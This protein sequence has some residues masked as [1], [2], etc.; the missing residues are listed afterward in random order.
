MRR[1]L[2]YLLALL[3]AAPLASTIPAHAQDW[4]KARLEASARH[5]EWV[6]LKH[7]GRTVN[8]YVVYPESSKKTPVV[9]LI[10]EIFGAS[11][12][13]HEMADEIAA[14]GYIVIAPD[15]LSGYGPN[16][17]GSDAFSGQEAAMKAVSGLDPAGVNADLDSAADYARTIPSSNGKLFVTGY[18]WGG[19]KSFA[20]ATHSKAISAAFVFYGPPPPD[21]D[22]KNITAPIF[23][24]YAG[25]DN[26]I[27][28]TI[29]ATVEA[30]KAIGRKYEP[31]TYEGASHGFMRLGEDPTATG[32]MVAANKKA[33]DEA[34]A[35]MIAVLK[36]LNSASKASLNTPRGAHV[37]NASVKT[38]KPTAQPA[39]G[40]MCHDPNMNMSQMSTTGAM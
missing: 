21:A 39:A 22:L 19:G 16:G 32:D 6:A 35:R 28:S 17:G 20:F 4:A 40:I 25:T 10:H 31:V 12:W 37:V 38:A 14:Q 34:F 30:M 3:L 2:P 9:L 26:R 7:D 8:A 18:C 36:Q 24:F 5:R 13:T 15:L 23:G 27:T 11:D 33:R 1:Q 29:P